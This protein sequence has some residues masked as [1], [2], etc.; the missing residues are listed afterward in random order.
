MRIRSVPEGKELFLLKATPTGRKSPNGA[1]NAAA[2]P[3]GPILA[4]AQERGE[5]VEIRR[6]PTGDLVGTMSVRAD[7]PTT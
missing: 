5:T 7:R 2:S 3:A 4:F 1:C 6:A